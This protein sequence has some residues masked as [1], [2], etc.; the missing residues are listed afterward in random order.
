MSF[1]RLGKGEGLIFFHTIYQQFVPVVFFGGYPSTN[2][3]ILNQ[4]A[5][6]GDDFPSDVTVG[7]SYGRHIALAE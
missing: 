6:M 3:E 7:S 1:W 5:Q 4:W 2:G